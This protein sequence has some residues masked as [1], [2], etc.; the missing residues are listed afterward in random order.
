MTDQQ[1][2][3]AVDE[4]AEQRGE[5][6]RLNKHICKLDAAIAAR[7][8]TI[9][10]LRA[11]VDK[12][13]TTVCRMLDHIPMEFVEGRSDDEPLENCVKRMAD[14]IAALQARVRELESGMS[15]AEYKERY[16]PTTE[17]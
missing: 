9:A 7:D 3:E 17:K 10:A 12:E 4:L 11:E 1:R 6:H 15:F 8:A 13:S 14:R 5:V 16:K 2:S